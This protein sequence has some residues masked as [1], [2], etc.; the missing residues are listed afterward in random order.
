MWKGTQ[1]I[2]SVYTHTHRHTHTHSKRE[3][4]LLIIRITHQYGSEGLAIEMG[5]LCWPELSLYQ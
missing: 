1:I 3:C 5:L 2:T 4:M